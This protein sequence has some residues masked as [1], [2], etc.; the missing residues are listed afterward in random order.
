[1]VE[2]EKYIPQ[3]DPFLLVDKIIKTESKNESDIIFSV[4]TCFLV[5]DKHVLCKDGVLQESGIIE[6][7]A[8][9]AAAM[10]GYEAVEN[11]R[12]VKLGFIGSLK[13]LK[14]YARVDAGDTL[15]TKVQFINEVMGVKIIKGES[16]V[17][18]TLIAECQM[19]IYLED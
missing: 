14:I 7:L 12:P 5:N 9:S 15:I 6:N 8:Q 19:Q 2:I 1:M 17:G 13:K 4:M 10:E 16:H 18:D 3:R 11:H